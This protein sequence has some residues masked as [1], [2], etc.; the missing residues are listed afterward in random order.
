[1]R[2]A[3]VPMRRRHLGA[4][5]RIEAEGSSRPW[6]RQV[7]VD[8]LT[9]R[10]RVYVVACSGRRVVG[11][12]GLWIVAGPTGG[13][14]H[15]TNISVDPSERR[16]GVAT[17]LLAHLARVAIDAGCTA[18]TLEVRRSSTGAQALYQRFGFLPVG[19]RRE[20]YGPGEDALIMWCH[21]LSSPEYGELIDDLSGSTGTISID[22][23]LSTTH[24]DHAL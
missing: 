14:A 13:D 4:V 20:Y 11:F 2:P 1:M 17:A 15:L 16:T 22:P 12:A 3:V 8:E 5:Q 21:D 9:S 24:T 6:S 10:D 23:A 7:F 18:W 19:S